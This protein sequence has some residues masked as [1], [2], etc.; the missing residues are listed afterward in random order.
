MHC[1]NCQSSISR[2]Q[3]FCVAANIT[4]NCRNWCVKKPLGHPP[5]AIMP[6][7]GRALA[8]TKRPAQA[9]L[10]AIFPRQK[11]GVFC[12]P[13]ASLSRNSHSL[14]ALP[15]SWKEVR[16]KSAG[17]AMMHRLFL[18]A[19]ARLALALATAAPAEAA[20]GGT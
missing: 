3:H 11:L 9:P 17:S 1:D 16:K 18:P 19:A 14:A 7:A 4:L 20:M 6:I 2:L 10:T 15:V 13:R 12:H 5:I 8:K